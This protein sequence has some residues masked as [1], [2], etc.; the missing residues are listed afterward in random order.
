MTRRSPAPSRFSSVSAW[1]GRIVGL[2]LARAAAIIGMFAAHV[3][4]S[5]TRGSDADGWGWLWVADGRPS[6]LFAVLAGV[7]ISLM[8]TTDRGGVRH[9]AVRVATRGL[10]LIAA[11]YLLDMLGTPIAVILTNLGVM[12][13]VVIPAMRWSPRVLA[14]AGVAVMVAGAIAYHY[15]L[16]ALGR[17]YPVARTFTYGYYPV[18]AWA[19][20]VL[21][22][23]A[24]GKRGLQDR[25]AATTLAWVGA[26]GTR[27]RL[28]RGGPGRGIRAMERP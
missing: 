13:L 4:D 10:L 3:G 18:M 7:T 22:G 24:V 27:V 16:G 19:G 23:M 15:V 17:R 25:Q 1:P 28:R 14:A 9:A 8:A 12:F 2:D 26:V 6:A 11:G 5:G 21:I 20:Y